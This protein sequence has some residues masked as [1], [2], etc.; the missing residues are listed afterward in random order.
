MPSV[1][2]SIASSSA[3]SNSAAEIGGRWWACGRRPPPSA[4]SPKSK[5][6]PWP[7]CA[8]SCAFWP[9]D[10]AAGS[11]SSIP[12]RVAPVESSAPH[13]TR[14]SI[15]RLLTARE[16]TRS[17]K[18]QIEAIGAS[19]RARRIASTAAW[20]TF[21]TASRPKRIAFSE[22][23]KLWSEELTSG[24]STSIPISAQRLTKNG[25]LSLVFITEEITAAMYSA[26]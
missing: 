19:S 1:S 22:T 25:T 15:A 21:L 17:Q 18:S 6:E 26:G 13:L 3:R 23:T 12:L 8:S 11:A 16:S 10:W 5:I 2:F 7:I 14:H 20:P 24:G 4:S 9:A